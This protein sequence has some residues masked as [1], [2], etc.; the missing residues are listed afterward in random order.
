MVLTYWYAKAF[1]SVFNKEIDWNSDTM[2]ATLHTVSYV[3]NQDTHDY[4]SDWTNELGTTNGYTA[5]GLTLTGQ[6]TT[7]SGPV[8]TLDST[9]DPQWTFTGAGN[10][11]RILVISDATPGTAA[12]NPLVI[13]SDFEANET[14]SGGGTFTYQVNA[15]GWST[16]TAA[17]AVGFP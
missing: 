11:A 12:T 6:T 3:P 15:S 14:A 13:W 9:T 5:G 4:Q 8:H 1:V 16:I 2:K 10:T 17:N 7:T